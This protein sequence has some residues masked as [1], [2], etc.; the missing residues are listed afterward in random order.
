MSVIDT[1]QFKHVVNYE[2]SFASAIKN[3]KSL[4]LKPG[5]PLLCSY[6]EGDKQ[7]W[8]LSI[9]T[10]LQGQPEV[11]VFPAF[12]DIDDFIKFVE[13]KLNVKIDF[14]LTEQISEE[15]DVIASVD[16]EG[17]TVLK[18]KEGVISGSSFWEE[19]K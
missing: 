14:D 11:K 16:S 8:F 10:L 13:S 6:K 3:I 12:D 15:S 4:G 7:R 9:G 5:E 17:K 2:G 18:I 1:I 19:L